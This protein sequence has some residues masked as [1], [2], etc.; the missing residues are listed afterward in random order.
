M[1]VRLLAVV[2]FSAVLL[3][4]CLQDED[5]GVDRDIRVVDGPADPDATRGEDEYWM[6]LVDGTEIDE[7]E[8]QPVCDVAPPDHRV[9][10][11]NETVTYDNRS[12]TFDPAEVGVLVAFDHWDRSSSCPEAWGLVPDP[13]EGYEREMG[14]W[15]PLSL[16]VRDDGTIIV[17]E[18][19]VLPGEAARA[20]YEGTPSDPETIRVDGSFEVQ[21]LGAWPQEQLQA[22]QP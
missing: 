22:G 20:S 3:A 11:A 18:H 5:T 10:R 15:G 8:S 19:A 7:R 16:T 4:G 21:L 17:D 12:Y 14:E 2:A 6:V 13:P 1:R 9:D